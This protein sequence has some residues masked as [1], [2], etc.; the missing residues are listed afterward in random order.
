M[1]CAV[2]II[3]NSKNAATSKVVLKLV[4]I[5][6]VCAIISTR[7]VPSTDVVYSASYKPLSAFAI[8]PFPEESFVI[9]EF[10]AVMLI[11]RFALD[12]GC[13][14]LSRTTMTNSAVSPGL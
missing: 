1:L 14:S 9:S 13:P 12:T 10:G 3:S 4:S 5:P 2:L 8:I 7:Y 11:N 6:S